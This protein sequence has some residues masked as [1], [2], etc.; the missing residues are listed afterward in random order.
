[1][2]ELEKIVEKFRKIKNNVNLSQ[3]VTSVA[4]SIQ[5]MPHVM[6]RLFDE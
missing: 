3:T 1:M 4:D 2:A 5:G 6:Y